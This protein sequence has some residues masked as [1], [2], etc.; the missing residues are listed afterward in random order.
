MKMTFVDNFRLSGF[1]CPPVSW[2]RAQFG[3]RA[4]P[5]GATSLEARARHAPQSHYPK[6]RDIAGIGI[7]F[8]TLYLLEMKSWVKMPF[9]D[10]FRLSSFLWKG[11]PG[12]V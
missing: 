5:G 9:V 8:L 12:F 4:A 3:R 1:S 2:S 6:V 11:V 7:V 10:S